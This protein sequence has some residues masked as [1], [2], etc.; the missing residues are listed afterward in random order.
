MATKKSKR[1]RENGHVFYKSSDCP[2]CPV[3]EKSKGKGSEFLALL[4]SPARSALLHHSIDT[5]EALSRYSEKEILKFH[6][7]GKASIPLFHQAL[8]DAGL[9]FRQDK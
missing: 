1:I 6:G 8:N 9:R 5:V 3:C 4:S 2:T 7:I